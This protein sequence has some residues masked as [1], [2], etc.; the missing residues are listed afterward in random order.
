MGGMRELVLESGVI[1]YQGF[2]GTGVYYLIGTSYRVNREHEKQANGWV[3][4]HFDLS[5]RAHSQ[6]LS[7]N[8]GT[9]PYR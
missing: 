7:D 1:I 4:L 2:V 5:W 6:T 8:F 9:K 3:R